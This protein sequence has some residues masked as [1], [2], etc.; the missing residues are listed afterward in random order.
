MERRSQFLRERWEE[1][2]RSEH[3]ERTPQEEQREA[4]IMLYLDIKKQARE[5]GAHLQG[6]LVAVERQAV[7]YRMTV[8]IWERSRRESIDTKALDAFGEAEQNRRFAHN[9][10]MD[11]VNILSRQCAAVGLDNEWRRRIGLERDDVGRWGLAVAQLIY[12]K[13]EDDHH[14]H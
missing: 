13:F 2:A 14:E 6:L 10:L 9:V 11:D 7:R 1:R 3:A 8:N 4:D 12:R 5:G